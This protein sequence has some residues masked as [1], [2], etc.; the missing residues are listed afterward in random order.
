MAPNRIGGPI[1]NAPDTLMPMIYGL[2]VIINDSLFVEGVRSVPRTWR[3]RLWSWP[4]R[5]WTRVRVEHFKRPDTSIYR[6]P[7]AFVMRGE[8]WRR[9]QRAIQEAEL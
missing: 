8:T 1:S 7:G 2:P 4:W 6:V 5:P 9:V 3:E